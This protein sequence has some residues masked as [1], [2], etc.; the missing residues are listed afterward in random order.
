M[1]EVLKQ[2]LMLIFNVKNIRKDGPISYK[3]DGE[4]TAEQ[5]QQVIAKGQLTWLDPQNHDL[6]FGD[7]SEVFYIPSKVPRDGGNQYVTLNRADG[8]FYYG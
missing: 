1:G 4:I 7:G 3:Y 5:V 2:Y 6:G 8:T